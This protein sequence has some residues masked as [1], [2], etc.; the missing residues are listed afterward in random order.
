M[1]LMERLLVH[2]PE[3]VQSDW[4]LLNHVRPGDDWPDNGPSLELGRAMVKGKTATQMRY[5]IPRFHNPEL[6]D[7]IAA[8]DDR[9]RV[10]VELVRNGDMTIDGWKAVLHKHGTHHRLLS[11]INDHD[12]PLGLLDAKE[13]GIR[14]KTTPLLNDVSQIGLK[15]A[16]ELALEHWP[17]EAHRL[18][19]MYILAPSDGTPRASNEEIMDLFECY[20]SGL[21][22]SGSSIVIPHGDENWLT[23]TPGAHEKLI[24]MVLGS[25]IRPFWYVGDLQL[26][27]RN[28]PEDKVHGPI[29]DVSKLLSSQ[30]RP[31]TLCARE[32]IS[33]W[34]ERRPASVEE[35]A[36]LRPLAEEYFS[37][38]YPGTLLR[39]SPETLFQSTD[40]STSG[41]FMV[42]HPVE[43]ALAVLSDSELSTDEKLRRVELLCGHGA[44]SLEGSDE[45]DRFQE[46]GSQLDQ[47][48]AGIESSRAVEFLQGL[49]TYGQ[50]WGKLCQGALRNTIRNVCLEDIQ[51]GSNELELSIPRDL[52]SELK[53]EMREWMKDP[54]LTDK[55]WDRAVRFVVGGG[56]SPYT[57]AMTLRPLL[58][59]DAGR[60]LRVIF[61]PCATGS[62][63]QPFGAWMRFQPSAVCSAISGHARE[64]YEQG[65][66]SEIDFILE[67]AQKNGNRLEEFRVMQE[68]MTTERGLL[69]GAGPVR[70]IKNAPEFLTS[71]AKIFSDRFG[72][73]TVRWQLAVELLEEWEGTLPE[74]LDVVDSTE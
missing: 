6:L 18:M 36:R 56:L 37:D 51:A 52:V 8:N 45:E 40:D 7:E 43:A 24:D 67:L 28:L 38:L 48:L 17:W 35:I 26:L 46:F 14:P 5:L 66:S 39:I 69:S 42:R 63:N 27:L 53:A 60:V 19:R 64:A 11:E 61:T 3:Q 68:V 15:S 10:A 32:I 58:D 72:D 73:D 55:E 33:A 70:D 1:T 9:L 59:E 25:A 71:V 31:E 2:A 44:F 57:T 13:F 54:N 23:E 41:L 74:L 47:L 4:A 65:D 34:L 29:P 30:D 21:D 16:L 22:E 12:T 50:V 20:Y 49:Q 62:T